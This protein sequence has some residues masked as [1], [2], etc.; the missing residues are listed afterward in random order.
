MASATCTAGRIGAGLVT[1]APGVGR[2]PATGIA[3]TA[4]VAPPPSGS[5]ARSIRACQVSAAL[6][7]C[8][9][10]TLLSAAG[11]AQG[12]GSA[13]SPAFVLDT[14]RRLS[15]AVSPAFVLDTGRRLSSAVSPA[16]VLDTR[17][18]LDVE[19]AGPTLPLRL[20]LHPARPNPFIH[21]TAIHFDLPV[22]GRIRL[23]ISDVAGRRVRTLVDGALAPGFHVSEWDGRGDG[24]GL[25]AGIYFVRLEAP[26]GV[27]RRRLVRLD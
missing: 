2:L 15:S 5:A 24:G 23:E 6:A 14:G 10:G 18:G 17:P 8:V 3:M 7:T 21:R 20:A 13:V 16:F 11:Y 27:L 1:A 4:R 22:G 19:P 26:G 25:R 12:V 9:L